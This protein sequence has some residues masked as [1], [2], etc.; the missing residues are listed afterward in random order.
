LDCCDCAPV[1]YQYIRW[2]Q[3]G[4]LGPNPCPPDE[5]QQFAAPTFPSATAPSAS[6]S[7]SSNLFTGS[8][9]FNTTSGSIYVW[10]GSNWLSGFGTSGT[11]G[12]NGTSGTSGTN[13]SSGTSGISGTSGTSGTGFNSINNAGNLRVLF[14]DGTTN[15]A[16][17]STYLTVTQSNDTSTIAVGIGT[18]NT[19]N[20]GNLF[21]GARSINEGGQLFLQ[22]ATGYT[23]ASMIDNYQ[24]RFRILRGN[25]TSSNAEDFSINHTTGQVSFTRYNSTSSFTGTPIDFLSFDSGG[26]ILT[27]PSKFTQIIGNT[28]QSSFNITHS[29]GDA[30]IQVN[31][32]SNST[33]QIYYPSATAGAPPQYTATVVDSNTVTIAFS[34][35]PSANQFIVVISK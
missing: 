15:A 6:V 24:N 5:I 8:M 34:S 10:N 4:Q 25:D 27:S 3:F 33:G 21:L 12:I 29:L 17:A 30:N 2:Q 19:S 20:E 28:V 32:R 35:A 16:T 14:S 22:R 23:S 13:G 18:T 1:I 26:N 31:I 7:G 11:S 9:Y